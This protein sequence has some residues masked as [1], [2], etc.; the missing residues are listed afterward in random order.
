MAARILPTPEQLRELLRYEPDTGKLFWKERPVEMFKNKQ[1]HGAW[2][3]KYSG[4]EA[5]TAVGNHGYLTGSVNDRM[6]TAHRVIWAVVYGEWPENQI[7]HANAIRTDNR[8]SNLRQATQQ[9]NNRNLR[10]SKANSSG[11]KGVS[12]HSKTGK[13]RSYISTKDG[14]KLHLGLFPTPE[15]AHAAFCDAAVKHHGKFARFE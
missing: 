14:R 13:W 7:D 8:I 9:E 6:Y 3:T 1:S 11:F 15:S 2:N 5:F 12:F 10:L 4:S